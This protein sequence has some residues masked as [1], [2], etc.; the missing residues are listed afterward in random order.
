MELTVTNHPRMFLSIFF[1]YFTKIVNA[2]TIP[3][4]KEVDPCKYWHDTEQKIQFCHWFTEECL[5]LE[6][7]I[8]LI[9]IL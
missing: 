9:F 2:G 5:Q 7:T 8:R 3:L 1:H 6:K 4:H